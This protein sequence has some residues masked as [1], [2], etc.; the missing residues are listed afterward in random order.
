MRVG[1]SPVGVGILGAGRANIAT[2][3]QIPACQAAANVRLVSLCDRLESVY[4]IAR[5]H[6]LRATTDYAEMLADPEVEM[7]QVATPDWCHLAHARQA[8]AAGKHVLLQKPICTSLGDLRELMAT[9]GNAPGKLKILL[10][11][12][13]TPLV[14]TLHHGILAGLIGELRHVCIQYRGHRYPIDDASS[15]YLRAESGGVWV[16][17]GLHWLDE[18]C[19]YAGATPSSVHT[20]TTRNDQ[21]P[22][23]LLGEG[24]NYWCGLFRL[25]EAVTCR[26]E[27]N[28]MLLADGLPGG[29]QRA[30]IGTEGELRV[31]Y[32]TDRARLFRT[33]ALDSPLLEPDRDGGDLPVHWLNPI[34]TFA[35]PQD[36]TVDSFRRAMEDFADEIRGG[37]ESPPF[38]ADSCRCMELLIRS[39]NGTPTYCAEPEVQP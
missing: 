27:Y 29:M 34:E 32:G 6:G 35:N 24:P 9:A 8:L 13:H 23:S 10:N 3:C 20:T 7:V 17:N 18:A 37:E 39:A 14:R 5:E 11:N 21:A 28:T 19:L 22:A 16:H 25:G 12:R 26:F 30:L 33:T 2:S 15:P 36:G 38:L 4:D 1:Q 31:A